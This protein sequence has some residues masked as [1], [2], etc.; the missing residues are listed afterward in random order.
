MLYQ[1]N[2]KPSVQI[3]FFKEKCYKAVIIVQNKN[4][5]IKTG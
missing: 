3:D 1:G 2:A 4:E 5:L